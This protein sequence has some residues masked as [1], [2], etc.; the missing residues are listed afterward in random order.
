MRYLI[1]FSY[2]GSKYYGYQKQPDKKSIQGELEK[3]LTQ[4]NSNTSVLVSAS[5]RT[6]SGVHALNQKAHFDLNVDI[7]VEKLKNSINK[8]L[9]ESIYIRNV[10]K[11]DDNF[12][13]RFDVKKKKY[14]YKINIGEYNPLDNNY[15]Y[16]YNEPLDTNKMKEAIKTFIGE[17]DF[18]SFVKDAIEKENCIRTIYSAYIEE[19]NEIISI[20]FEGNGFLR[21]MVRN[22]VGALIEVGSGKRKTEEIQEILDNKD[23]KTA[24]ITAPSN[25]L[26]LVDVY[27]N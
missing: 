1:T 26:Y 16:Q 18:T 25:G 7:P 8:M 14:T 12:H 10:E 3:V 22:M 23:R 19:E 17:H 4:I 24:G 2:D 20:T 9:S 27:Y 11:V 15:I 6:D 5:G 21:Y 13:A